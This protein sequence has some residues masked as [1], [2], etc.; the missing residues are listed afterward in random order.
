MKIWQK[1][2]KRII[3]FIEPAGDR[4]IA[5][6]SIDSN[7]SFVYLPAYKKIRRL[8]SHVRNQTFMGSDFSYEDMATTGYLVDYNGKLLGQ[9]DKYYNIELTPKPG[10]KVS[11]SKLIV[12][13]SKGRFKYERLEYFD[14]KG[15]K[16]KEEM[17]ENWQKYNDKYWN[18]TH[19][20]M[21]NLKDN[22]KTLLES[23]EIKYDTGFSDE[24]FTQ[25][26]MKRPAR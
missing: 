10:S 3:K 13:I 21:I 23:E 2:G 11:Y 15:E 26:N 24:I 25:R 1:E 5:F 17:R 18:T 14:A 22:H 8:A 16:V 7:T 6:L 4:G 12:H 20:R 9:D 19:I